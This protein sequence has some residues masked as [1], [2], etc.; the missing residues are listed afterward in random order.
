MTTAIES[1]S[2]ERVCSGQVVDWQLWVRGRVDDPDLSITTLG[3]T[4]TR[5]KTKRQ[6]AHLSFAFRK[7]QQLWHTISEMRNDE[8]RRDAA[9]FNLPQAIHIAFAIW[10]FREQ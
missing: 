2:S 7:C 3:Q 6:L 5:V 8:M 1:W 9:I 4:T 10:N